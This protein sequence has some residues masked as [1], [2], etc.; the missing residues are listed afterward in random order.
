MNIEAARCWRLILDSGDIDGYLHMAIDEA[1]LWSCQ[2]GQA[3]PTLRFYTW[4]HPTLSVGYSQK[5]SKEFDITTCQK[6]KYPVVRRIT[7]GRAVLH[8]QEVTYSV[9]ISQVDPLF[10]RGVLQAYRNLATGLLRGCRILGINA[11]MTP[12][13]REKPLQSHRSPVCFSSASWY[14]ILVE[15]KKLI[16]SAQKRFQNALLQQGSIL[17][18]FNPQRWVDILRV[19][20]TTLLEQLVC[21]T[22]SIKDHIP[23]GVSR[24]RVISAMI[25]GFEQVHGITFQETGLTVLE[26]ERAHYLYRTKYSQD[27]WNYRF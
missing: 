10:S 4:D 14:E 11:Q 19:K 5:V 22:T 26:W 7:G 23:E 17:M 24:E 27:T 25:R 12:K 6:L 15:G 13:P 20:S 9:V 21:H 18:G 8:D 2:E 3:P 16:G 1:I